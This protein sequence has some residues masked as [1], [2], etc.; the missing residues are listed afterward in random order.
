MPECITERSR[1]RLSLINKDGFYF[2]NATTFPVLFALVR[3]LGLFGGHREGGETF[4]ECAVRELAEEL[5]F[6]IPVAQFEF[7]TSRQ[8][9]DL[10]AIGGTLHAE[11][12]WRRTLLWKR[13]Q[14]PKEA[15]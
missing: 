6:A 15:C 13:S 1:R 12:F 4:L 14:L 8:G 3:T 2:N 11:F 10:E 5:S 9:Q 7:L